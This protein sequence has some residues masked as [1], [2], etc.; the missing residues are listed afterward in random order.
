[1]IKAA[2][3]RRTLA[4]HKCMKVFTTYSSKRVKCYKCEPKATH[5]FLGKSEKKQ[6]NSIHFVPVI[7]SSLTSIGNVAKIIGA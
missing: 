5:R 4:C 3:H 6:L 7:A 2:P 1:M